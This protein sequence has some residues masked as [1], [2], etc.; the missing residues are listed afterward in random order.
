M[1]DEL[2]KTDWNRTAKK[3]ILAC[4]IIVM[5]L[6]FCIVVLLTFDGIPLPYSLFII[7]IELALSL[8]VI[9]MFVKVSNTPR[10]RHRKV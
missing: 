9:F 3:W 8:M 7:G 5:A 1:D 10:K 6:V 4:K 2:D